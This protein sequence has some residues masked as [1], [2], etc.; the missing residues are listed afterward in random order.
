MTIQINR[1]VNKART[2]SPSCSFVTVYLLDILPL[3]VIS[4][5]LKVKSSIQYVDGLHGGYNYSL[6]THYSFKC[7]II[8]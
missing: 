8:Y 2:A 6:P 7:C 5:Q 3:K 4:N 1:S